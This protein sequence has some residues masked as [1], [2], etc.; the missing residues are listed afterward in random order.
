[1]RDVLTELLGDSHPA[2]SG[3]LTD[4]TELIE[5]GILDS[6]ALAAMLA[7]IEQQQ[8]LRVPAEDVVYDNFRTLKDITCLVERLRARRDA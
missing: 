3:P 2:V 7:V 5:S 4:S 8:G 6:L 1:M